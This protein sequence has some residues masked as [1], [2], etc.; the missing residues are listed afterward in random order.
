MI[1]I[2]C[3]DCM[4]RCCSNAFLT[5]LLL[6]SEEKSF[7][8]LSEL[9]E[10]PF[11]NLSLL[12]KLNGNCILLNTENQRC[13]DYNNRPIE[14]RIYP[15]LLDFSKPSVDVKLDNRF[16][17]HFQTLEYNQEKILEFVKTLDL[18][19]DWIRAY[20]YLQGC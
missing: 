11:R 1:K 7:N 4:N 19:Q 13:T 16:C 18:P 10:T 6:P 9:I 14:C 17:P 3:L 2:N 12:R 20:E 15:L 8:G 5:P